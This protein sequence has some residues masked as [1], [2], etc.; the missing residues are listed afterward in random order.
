MTN[1]RS[2]SGAEVLGVVV[3][4]DHVAFGEALCLAVSLEPDLVCLGEAPTL[5]LGLELVRR[6][7]PDVVVLDRWLPDGDGVNAIALL[8]GPAP[9]CAVVM[10]TGHADMEGMRA[11]LA[12]GA[13]R[14]LPK[15]APVVEIIAAIRA[16]G[17]RGG[18]PREVATT[19]GPG[20]TARELEVLRLL[21]EGLGPA[22]IAAALFISVH[23][24]R[25]HVKKVLAK[26][27]AHSQLEAVSVARGRGLLRPSVGWPGR[28]T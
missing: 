8:R 18:R 25:G 26:L 10:V 9:G 20:L 12:A 24:C 5:A 14:L 1:Y 17:T 11:A 13:A 16:Q 19:S 27:G 15:E 23:T 4:D 7:R 6:A 2:R 28:E 22:G 21:G 3:V